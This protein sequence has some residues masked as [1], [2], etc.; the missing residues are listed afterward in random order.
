M[1]L[2]KTSGLE[3]GIADIAAHPLTKYME[4]ASFAV[5]KYKKMEGPF[6]ADVL[7]TL[8][9][10]A[11]VISGEYRGRK[12]AVIGFDLHDSDFDLT[13]E[14]PIFMFNLAAY[15]VGIDLKGKTSYVCGDAIDLNPNPEAA[16]A[17][18]KTPEGIEY[19]LELTYPCCLS[20]NRTERV[21]E[22]HKG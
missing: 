15:L 4:D 13:T 5:S 8:D 19:K 22:L 9:G 14:Y 7:I 3:G 6:W 2:L 1:E 17:V 10:T 16:E 18:V 11:A 20:I 21:Y 12:T